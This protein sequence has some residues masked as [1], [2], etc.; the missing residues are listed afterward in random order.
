MQTRSRDVTSDDDVDFMSSKRAQNRSKG[1]ANSKRSNKSSKSVAPTKGVDGDYDSI[2]DFM[3][4]KL[5]KITFGGTR[6]DL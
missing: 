3:L 1:S 4:G 5:V 6:E 2:D